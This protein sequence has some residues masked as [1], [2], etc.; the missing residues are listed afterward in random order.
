MEEEQQRIVRERLKQARESLE[1]AKTILT[2]DGE[3]NFVMNS[4]Y[5]AFLN[6]VLGL[7][8]AKGITAT[9]HSVA[10]S[11]FERE[12]SQKG[13]DD[14]FIAALRKAFDLR[15]A[16]S[17]EGQKKAAPEDVE[18]LLPLAEEFIERVEWLIS[19]NTR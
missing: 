17:C 12:F 19:S 9:M 8:Q 13:I 7:L 5:Y 11:L 15:P 14:R 18:K 1:E 4:L 3:A 6:P 2:W 10:I 16:C